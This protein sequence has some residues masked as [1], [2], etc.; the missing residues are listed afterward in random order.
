MTDRP[1]LSTA[2]PDG[3]L[4]TVTISTATFTCF[5]MIFDNDEGTVWATSTQLQF[6]VQGRAHLLCLRQLGSETDEIA[7]R[8]QVL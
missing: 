2:I 1:W 8:V 3:D 6:P 7:D 4:V 5:L